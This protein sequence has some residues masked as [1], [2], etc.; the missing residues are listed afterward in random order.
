MKKRSIASAV[1]MGKPKFSQ[2]RMNR[3]AIHVDNEDERTK[4]CTSCLDSSFDLVVRARSESFEA[5]VSFFFVL[6]S[7]PLSISVEEALGP[8]RNISSGKERSTQLM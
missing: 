7:S 6:W 4:S 1:C 8:L 3:L 5:I 2:H